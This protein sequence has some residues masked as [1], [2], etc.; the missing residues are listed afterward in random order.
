PDHQTKGHDNEQPIFRKLSDDGIVRMPCRR[1]V[2][3]PQVI[4]RFLSFL[5][6]LLS[7]I[8]T[9]ARQR[10]FRKGPECVEPCAETIINVRHIA[11]PTLVERSPGNAP[12]V[13]CDP[14]E[15][16]CGHQKEGRSAAAAKQVA[17][18]ASPQTATPNVAEHGEIHTRPQKQGV[19]WPEKPSG[20]ARRRTGQTVHSPAVKDKPQD[21]AHVLSKY[22]RNQ[23][24][25]VGAHDTIIRLD[26]TVLASRSER[27]DENCDSGTASKDAHACTLGGHD[28]QPRGHWAFQKLI[29]APF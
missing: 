6:V 24:R 27:A 16:Q 7:A 1:D 13:H 18:R 9:E 4:T 5:N 19:N 14:H 8:R 29:L 25:P 3:Y 10:M 20:R 17:K 21:P 26:T 11:A 2:H 28:R 22:L 15:H 12:P 23:K